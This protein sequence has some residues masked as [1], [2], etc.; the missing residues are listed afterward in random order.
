MARPNNQILVS[1]LVNQ[2]VNRLIDEDKRYAMV[3]ACAGGG[4]G[5]AGIIE[6]YDS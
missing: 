4:I 5:Y 2:A 6:R 1:R 3:A